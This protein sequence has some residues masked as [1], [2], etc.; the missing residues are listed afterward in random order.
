MRSV[1]L[2]Q[3]LKSRAIIQIVKEAILRQKE[4]VKPIYHVQLQ[5]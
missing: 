4:L 1:R 5:A 2:N 3:K